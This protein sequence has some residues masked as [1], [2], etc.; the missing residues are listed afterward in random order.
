[1]IGVLTKAAFAD[2]RRLVHPRG[3]FVTR[4]GGKR[5]NEPIIEAVQSFF[6]FYM[7]LFMTAT[8]LLAKMSVPAKKPTLKNADS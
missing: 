8:F 1:M 5:V 7:L 4:F 6:L 3:V 2:L